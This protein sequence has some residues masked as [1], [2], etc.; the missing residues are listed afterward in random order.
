[1]GEKTHRKLEIEGNFL[2]IIKGIYENPTGNVM[3]N[4]ERLKAFT[5]KSGIG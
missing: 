2:N 1:M 4:G 5:L 3:L